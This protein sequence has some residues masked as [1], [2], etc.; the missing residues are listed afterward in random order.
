MRRGVGA[1]LGLVVIMAVVGTP[2]APAV[3]SSCQGTWQTSAATN[4]CGLTFQGFPLRVSGTAADATRP[5]DLIVWIQVVPLFGLDAFVLNCRG[6]T[7]P[8]T[9]QCSREYG[10]EEVP[11]PPIGAP[12]ACR[13]DGHASG[14]FGCSSG[15]PTPTGSQCLEA[16]WQLQSDCT[17]TF[18]GFPLHVAAT[19]ASNAPNGIPLF[20]VAVRV[21]IEWIDTRSSPP[22]VVELVACQAAFILE[23]KCSADA[24]GMPAGVA[25]PPAGTPI[26]CVVAGSFGGGFSCTSA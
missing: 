16:Y 20:L 9:A 19:A 21:S 11:A 4:V 18:N 22:K 14:T 5:A 23:T 17:L 25:P 10:S 15:V 1:F 2:P 7:G 6:G 12:L 8:G 26:R 13:A 24:A 3:G